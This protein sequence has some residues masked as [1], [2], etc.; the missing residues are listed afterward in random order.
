NIEAIF[1]E[2]HEISRNKKFV[3]NVNNRVRLSAKE[4]VRVNYYIYIYIYI[5]KAIYSFHNR[6]K[7]FQIYE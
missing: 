1:R 7:Q 5:Y 6:F 4:S 2:R 3:Q